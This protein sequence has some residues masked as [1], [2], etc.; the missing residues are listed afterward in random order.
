[1]MKV[2]NMLKWIPNAPVLKSWFMLTWR[3]TLCAIINL[4]LSRTIFTASEVRFTVVSQR[5]S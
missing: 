3:L 2:L 1:M 4:W 5:S